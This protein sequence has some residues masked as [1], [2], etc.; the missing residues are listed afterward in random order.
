MRVLFLGPLA[1]ALFAV[2]SYSASAPLIAYRGIMNA[3]SIMPAGL[4]GGAI[5]QGSVFTITGANLGPDSAPDLSDPL[6]TTLGGVTI[7]VSQGTSSVNAIPLTLSSTSI[8]AIMPSNAPVGM[9]S[10]RINYNNLNSNPMPVSVV[11]TQFGISTV[12]AMGN[13]PANIQNDNG[14]GTTTGNTL[15][16]PAYPG[17]TV[18]LTGTGLGA[19]T[20]DTALSPDTSNLTVQTEV[21][22]GGESVSVTSNG[23]IAPG[24][25]QIGFVIPDDALL[26]CWTPVYVRTA[27]TAVSNFATISIS[28]DGTACQ[29]PNNIL[30][31]ALINGGNNGTYA[32]VRL[33]VRHDAGVRTPRDATTDL[34]GAYEASEVAGPSNFNPIFSLPPAGS[35]TVYTLVGDL[36]SNPTAII[37]GIT[38]PTGMALDDGGGASLTG[39]KG[40][41]TAIPTIYPGISGVQ[42]GSI[43]SSLP[44]TQQPFLASG[45][46][47]LSLAGGNDIG[48]TSTD[49][50]VPQPFTWSNRDQVLA[51]ARAKGLSLT[52]TG[53]DPAASEFVVVMSA[54]LPSNSS[55]VAACIV[56]PGA[57]SFM[58]PA[59]VLANLPATRYRTIQSRGAVY[60]GQWN[61]TSPPSVSAAGLDFGAFLPIF[62]GGKTVIFQ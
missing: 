48:S 16:T 11:A 18:Y 9:N 43:V 7:T 5:A 38:P 14:D 4:P 50:S 10:V 30:A 6:L 22:V 62:V 27:G 46:L 47:T 42:L 54:D 60:I 23:R 53:G 17:Q 58:V 56:P 33:N 13:G 52:W 45:G 29:E 8:T 20:T 25:D 40:T 26:G 32:A 3:S 39:D 2:P 15:Q 34:F 1:F 35:C 31:S 36:I 57:S 37:P 49:A 24:M 51:I 61:L 55:A 21:F 44:L 59:D 19:I 28:A 41:K 12:N